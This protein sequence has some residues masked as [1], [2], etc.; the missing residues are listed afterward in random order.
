M[1]KSKIEIS[2]LKNKNYLNNESWNALNKYLPEYLGRKFPTLSPTDIEDATQETVRRLLRYLD[3]VESVKYIEF[4]AR[5]VGLKM[6]E[7][8]NRH[9]EQVV[10]LEGCLEAFNNIKADASFAKELNNRCI[11]EALVNQA[12][13]DAKDRFVEIRMHLSKAHKTFLDNYLV[14]LAQTPPS[15]TERQDFAQTIGH[16]EG[17]VNITFHR[18]RQHLKSLNVKPN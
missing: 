11:E 18:I 15:R 14:F 7:M 17:N 10:S 3:K 1:H 6:I 12:K 5:S 13:L 9:E 8:R 4:V 2:E 16:T